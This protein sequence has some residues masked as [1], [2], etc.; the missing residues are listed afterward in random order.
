MTQLS[1]RNNGTA[2]GEVSPYDDVVSS[3]ASPIESFNRAGIDVQIATAHRYPRS[4]AQFLQESED[5][6]TA[7]RAV[8]A[9]CT[10]ALPRG[11]KSIT[12][13]SVRLAEI[14][15]STWGNLRV[16]AMI[17]GDDGRFVVAQCIALDLQKN[18]G[19][20]V[21]ARRRVT[22]RNGRRFDDD[23]I[24]VASNAA[25][26]IALRNG[27]FRVIPRTYVDIIHDLAKQV[28]AGSLEALESTRASWI[29][30]LVGPGK[31]PTE[32]ELYA[33]LGVGGREDVGTDE[34]VTMQGWQ[35]AIRD[36]MT[37]YEEIYAPKPEPAKAVAE[38]KGATKSERL[39]AKLD[40][41]EPGS[42]G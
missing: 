20:S 28:A 2:G 35:T 29:A 32:R 13:P 3:V 22:D 7:N 16:S 24:A 40:V 31:I 18:V 15:A 21:E 12:G 34:I 38:V 11:G 1:T 42:D 25:I 9:S 14:L 39:A 10:Y 26:S 41:P 17:T 36:K 5:L 37:T 27:I 8:A 33:A 23:M 6:V 19:I 4:V 30:A